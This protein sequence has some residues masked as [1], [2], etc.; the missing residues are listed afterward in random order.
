MIQPIV[1]ESHFKNKH[2]LPQEVWYQRID[3]TSVDTVLF[4]PIA[5]M[6]DGKNVV[7]GSI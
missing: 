3:P 2:P 4:L 5:T 1:R 6:D 7:F